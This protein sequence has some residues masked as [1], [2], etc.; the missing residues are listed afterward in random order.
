MDELQRIEKLEIIVAHLQQTV[1]ALD[2]MVRR[3]TAQT[4]KLQRDLHRVRD[5]SQNLRQQ[6]D[7]WRPLP[8]EKP[9]HY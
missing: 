2:E 3:T 8:D 6:V 1:D 4:D 9:P 7:A 5:E